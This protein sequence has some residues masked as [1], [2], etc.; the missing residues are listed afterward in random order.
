MV[1]TE[2]HAWNYV[3]MEDDNWYA[4]DTTWDD[5]IIIGGGSVFGV[6]KHKYFLKGSNDFF[7]THVEDGD[8]SGKG[9]VFEYPTISTTNYK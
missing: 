6:N 7:Q 4:V 8:V 1:G 9:Q 3:K 2:P 5:P